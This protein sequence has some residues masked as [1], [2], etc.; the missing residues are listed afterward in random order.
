MSLI[1]SSNFSQPVKAPTPIFSNP[2]DNSAFVKF[3]HFLNVC[4]TISLTL[5]GIA[6]LVISELY[7]KNPCPSNLF[8]EYFSPL[9]SRL[10]GIKTS[11]LFIK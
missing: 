7:A 6:I 5:P 1:T 11:P 10:S 4:P 2:S 9:Y 8:T 3:A